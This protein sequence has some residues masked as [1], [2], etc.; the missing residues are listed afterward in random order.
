[1]VIWSALPSRI[2]MAVIV[3]QIVNKIKQRLIIYVKI[4]CG[5]DDRYEV[6][7]ATYSVW[8]TF[9]SHKKNFVLVSVVA[10]M[11]RSCQTMA[12]GLGL[13]KLLHQS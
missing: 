3:Y 5:I 6:M 11:L 10:L 8:V 2:N 13:E 1:M 7:Y 4:K 9:V 12:A